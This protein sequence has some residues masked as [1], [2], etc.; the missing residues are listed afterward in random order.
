MI[1]VFEQAYND[2]MGVKIVTPDSVSVIYRGVKIQN[3]D[4]NIKIYNLAKGGDFYR[5]VTPEQYKVFT[6]NGFRNGVYEICM[7][8][9]KRTLDTLS[10][11]IRNEMQSR[12]NVKHYD[13]LKEWRTTIMN[14]VT[15]IIN[16]K[17]AV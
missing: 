8:N 13:S 16:L 11:K 3:K 1:Q 7:E 6:E 5:E 12:K 2:R 17:T 4:N 15:E 10:I 9:Y 14:K